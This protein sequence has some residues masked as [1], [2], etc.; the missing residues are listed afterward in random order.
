MIETMKVLVWQWSRLG[1]PPRF[2]VL[3]ARALNAQPGVSAALSLSTRAQLSPAMM[4]ESELLV[5][6]YTSLP[7]FLA[8][9][10]RAPFD[11]RR[12]VPR[13][14]AIKPDVA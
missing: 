6:T 3:L 14:R 4:A 10:M 9:A 8:R 1:G 2:G 11:L 13:V 7:G 5:D 12:L